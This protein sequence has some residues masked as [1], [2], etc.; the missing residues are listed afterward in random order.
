MVGGRAPIAIEGRVRPSVPEP[1]VVE[2]FGGELEGEG[3][4]G[5]GGEDMIVPDGEGGGGSRRVY[6]TREQLKKTCESN[7]GE[8][9]G[10]R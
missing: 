8:S 5:V 7:Q 3:L 10:A 6:Q 9:G 1:I 4:A 2:G